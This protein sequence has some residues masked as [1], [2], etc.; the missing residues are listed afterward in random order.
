MLNADETNLPEWKIAQDYWNFG[1]E[2][3][4]VGNRVD[5]TFLKPGKY[6]VQLIVSNEPDP[7]GRAKEAC[8]SKNIIV[9][10]KP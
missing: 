9:F 5:K 8:V 3:I 7:G 10:N 2:T 6:N 1:D 4:A